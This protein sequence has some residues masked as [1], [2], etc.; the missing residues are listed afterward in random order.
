LPST[1]IKKRLAFVTIIYWVLLAYI[2]AALVWWF[3]SLEKQNR[4]MTELRLSELETVTPFS[5]QKKAEIMDLKRRKTAQYIGEG[6]IFMLLI[7]IGAVYIF[8]ATRRQL[9]LGQQ[10]QNF[11]MAVTHE[12]KT[13]IAITTLNLET[14]QK[15][16]LD[17]TQQQRI[18]TNSLQ[19][20]ARLNDLCNNILL[21]AQ[22]EAGSI[23]FTKE[24][25]ELGALAEDCVNHFRQ[26]FPNRTIYFSTTEE[27]AVSG[28]IF[29]LQMLINNLLENAIKYSPKEKPVTVEV[30]L[31]GKKTLLHV[32]DEGP[33]IPDVEKKRVFEKFYRI[34]DE[35]TRTSKGSGLG[36][37]LCSRIMKKHDGEIKLTDNHPQGSI[38]TAVFRSQIQDKQN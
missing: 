2:I 16:R 28:E 6:M 31:K 9:R 12:L 14:L 30:E 35:Q 38:F 33:G 23:R 24:E 26:R 34:G 1:L 13:P 36:L 29:S 10:Q 17:E 27:T 18:I 21:T 32:K 5:S 11:M 15:R 25:L 8:R 19:E 7:L 22:L 37:Y 20:A 4:L 3:I